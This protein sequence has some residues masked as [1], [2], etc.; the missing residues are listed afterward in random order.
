MSDYK[1]NGQGRPQGDRRRR[2]RGGRNRGPSN[3]PDS[4]SSH[5]SFNR[6]PK[7]KPLTG[8]QKF[9]SIVTF[10]LYKPTPAPRP[11]NH[12]TGQPQRT[13]REE[14]PIAR[15]DRQERENNRQERGE[16]SDRGERQERG[17]RAERPE[18]AERGERRER[19]PRQAP[20]STEVTNE[21]LYVGNLSYDASESDLFE[22]FSGS[23]RVKNAEVVV[24][25][26][27]QRSKGFAFVTMMSVDEAKK[28][29]A[30]LNA[31]DFM[32]RP[33]VVGGAKPLAPRDERDERP[34]RDDEEGGESQEE[35]AQPSEP[36]TDESKPELAA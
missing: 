20:V 18:R 12:G 2:R 3:A 10:G 8:F 16:R 33:L 21:R 13:P 24:N 34:S 26:R 19:P 29:V 32:G 22:L 15:S 30:D 28:A 9:L 4:P 35:A 36:A 25:N 5:K 27:T 6:P 23:G 31:K 17:E 1:P 14:G 11:S 7:T